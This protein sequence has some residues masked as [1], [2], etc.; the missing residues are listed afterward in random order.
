MEKREG[1][2]TVLVPRM[3]RVEW[4]P[5]RPSRRQRAV[6]LVV[7]VLYA[8][9]N[10]AL[11][12]AG[13]RCTGPLG[14]AAGLVLNLVVDA[15]LWSMLRMPRFGAALALCGS[16]AQ[17]VGDSLS[18]GL[19]APVSQLTPTTVPMAVSVM[20][21]MM[22]HLLPRREALAWTAA[23]AVPAVEPWHS[24]WTTLYAGLSAVVLPALLALYMRARSELLQSLRERA[25]SAEREKYLLAERAKEAERQRLAAEMHDIVTHHVTEIVLH[26]GALQVSAPDD[27]VRDAARQIREAGGRTL[28]E[29]RD[30]VRIVRGGSG[31]NGGGGGA[32]EDGG[33]A[34]GGGAGGGRGTGANA[35]AGGTGAPDPGAGLVRLARTA[36]AELHL[37]GDPGTVV[38]AVARA[39]YRVVQESLTNA[40]KHAQGARVTVTVRYGA[41]AVEITVHNTAPSGPP[42]DAALAA[43]GSGT[44]L[45]GLGHRV[46]LLGGSLSADA[47][48]E[49]GF[50]VLARMPASVPVEPVP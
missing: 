15:G 50:R 9:G 8:V 38:P 42:P 37:A 7:V 26:A 33:A 21:W 1:A 18:P 31:G 16:L 17:A 34:E 5:Q 22:F 41:H 6:V 36:G 23:V 48:A 46:A 3:L 44:G 25:E 2:A 13:E 30:L 19:F 28:D 40:R 4:P 35:G 24:G 29:L 20:V 45:A 43:S 12:V 10:I 49:G 14:P 47:T 39:A 27:D 32:G 11:Y